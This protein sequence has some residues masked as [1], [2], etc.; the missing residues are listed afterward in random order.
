MIGDEILKKNCGLG[1]KE[2]LNETASVKY[3]LRDMG[4]KRGCI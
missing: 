1:E 4:E 2:R 3:H